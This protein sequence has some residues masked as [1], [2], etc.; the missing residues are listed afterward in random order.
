M[1]TYVAS[2]VLGDSTEGFGFFWGLLLAL[3]ALAA[4]GL[5]LARMHL[6][7]R[8]PPGGAA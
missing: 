6:P 3:A 1:S 2:T 5:A 4:L 8:A 7:D